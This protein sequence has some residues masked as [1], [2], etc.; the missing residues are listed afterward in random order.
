MSNNIVSFEE[1]SNEILE[2]QI[3]DDLDWVADSIID[4]CFANGKRDYDLAVWLLRDVH[5]VD[6]NE[7]IGRTVL[8]MYVKKI[9]D[10]G[11]WVEAAE[12]RKRL[13]EQLDQRYENLIRRFRDMELELSRSK[14]EMDIETYS[15]SEMF[16]D[17]LSEEG[18]LRIESTVKKVFSDEYDFSQMNRKE[19]YTIMKDVAK[20]AFY[21]GSYSTR[22]LRCNNDAHE[23]SLSFMDTIPLL[24]DSKNEFA[25]L[26]NV[27]DVMTVAFNERDQTIVVTFEF[28]DFA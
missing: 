28:F 8:S 18:R 2:R 15:D 1:K 20:H 17:S 9:E 27:F 26:A 5:M 11:Y 23:L 16:L 21:D 22:E 24:G 7:G 3:M 25:F 6:E 19:A 14:Q 4:T 13:R 10:K 12:L